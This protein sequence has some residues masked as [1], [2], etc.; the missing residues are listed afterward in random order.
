[1]LVEWLRE[2]GVGESKNGPQAMFKD[3]LRGVSEQPKGAQ[4]EKLRLL[5]VGSLSPQNACARSGLFSMV[6]IDLNSQH[7]EIQ[8][9]DFMER[10]VPC[11][12]EA[13]EVEGFDVVSLSLVVNYVPD[14]EGRGAML[15]RVTQF[16][17]RTSN[18]AE[19]IPGLFLVLPAPCVT[20]SRYLDEA[21][22][23]EM[24]RSLGF[25][26]V[27]SRITSKLV[28]HYYSWVRK[29][30]A[31]VARFPK[32]ELRQGRQMNNFAIVLK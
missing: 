32:K 10:P 9:Q 15:R 24:M 14:A 23:V 1:M 8:Q 5:E 27:K 26:V 21:R 31:D 13:L 22:L 3:E 2:L 19:A 6:R 18:A 4:K 30:K 29:E 7:P 11:G 17:R 25:S 20:N 12:L 28:Y 16:L